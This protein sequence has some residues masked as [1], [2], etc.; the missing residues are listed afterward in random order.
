M[1]TRDL[2]LRI[3]PNFLIGI[4]LV[5]GLPYSLLADGVLVG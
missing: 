1:I 4:S 3:C 2:V 5:F